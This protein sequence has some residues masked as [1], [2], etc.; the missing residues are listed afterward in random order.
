M[1]ELWIPASKD[2]D[3]RLVSRFTLSDSPQVQNPYWLVRTIQPVTLVDELLRTLNI[4][5]EEVTP[6]GVGWLTTHTVPD[7]KRWRLYAIHY[8]RSNGAAETATHV[9]INDGTNYCNIDS[10]GFSAGSTNQ[11]VLPTPIDLKEAW[12]IDLQISVHNA[13]DKMTMN[14]IYTEED[15]Y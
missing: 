4:S 3:S 10:P 9:R 7:G 15:A 1:A 5:N 14:I 6:S 12:T 13:G 8:W 11:C 2:I